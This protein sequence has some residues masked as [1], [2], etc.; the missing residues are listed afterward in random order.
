MS[1]F[2]LTDIGMGRQILVEFHIAEFNKNLLHKDIQTRGY[3]NIYIRVISADVRATCF[4][5]SLGQ[6]Q[7][8]MKQ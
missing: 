5:L 1:S 6:L 4:A 8:C 3:Y 2:V 7:A